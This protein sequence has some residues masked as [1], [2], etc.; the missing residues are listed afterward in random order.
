MKDLSNLTRKE[1]VII[2]IQLTFQEGSTAKAIIQ[3]RT[4]GA[5]PFHAFLTSIGKQTFSAC[6]NLTSI[7]FLNPMPIPID[8]DIFLSYMPQSRSIKVPNNSI[9]AYKNADVWKE[10]N[11][12]EIDEDKSHINTSQQVQAAINRKQYLFFDTETTG[13]PKNYNAPISDLNNWP[14]LGVVRK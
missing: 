1:F 13:V 14:R 5:N 11:I 8:F 3:S 7:T 12:V 10:F 6:N 4:D 2:S 9:S